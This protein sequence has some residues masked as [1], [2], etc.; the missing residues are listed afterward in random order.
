[1]RILRLT[2]RN[3]NSLRCEATI[4]FDEP[5]LSRAG[6]F[7]ITGPTGAGKTT[8]LDALTLA[9]Y[10]RTPRDSKANEIM[11]NGSADCLAEVEFETPAGRYRAAYA[12]K[13][14][15]G[16]PDGNLQAAQRYL[17]KY[18][19][20]TGEWPY[21]AERLVREVD[22][23]IEA[24]TGL[25]F[26]RFTRSVMLTQGDFARFLAA[27][28]SERGDLLERITGTEIYNQISQAAFE[29]HK[30]A[31]QE[32]EEGRRELSGLELLPPTERTATE[33]QAAEA[34]A[35]AQ[36][37]D[38][39]HKTLLA[40]LEQYRRREQL[41]A[42]L[43]ATDTALTRLAEERDERAEELSI[44]EVV[45]RLRPLRDDL[46][47]WE[48]A[49]AELNRDQERERELSATVLSLTGQLATATTELTTAEA[50]LAAWQ[51]QLPA[52]QEALTR[53]EKL[54]ER[55]RGLQTSREEKD[56]DLQALQAR[57][58]VT[59][60]TITEQTAERDRLT[61]AAAAD[62]K[63]LEEHRKLAEAAA[64]WSNW[65]V[66]IDRR[67]ER[68]GPLQ[69]QLTQVAALEKEATRLTAERK[70]LDTEQHAST[71]RARLLEQQVTALI[72]VELLPVENGRI[73]ARLRVAIEERTTEIGRL[74]RLGGALDAYREFLQRQHAIDEDLGHLER[75]EELL[76]PRLFAA[77]LERDELLHKR[78][79]KRETME[80][81]R[82][83][84]GHETLRRTLV[85]G[86]PCPVC[87]ALDH[88]FADRLGASDFVAE[89]EVELAKAEAALNRAE[90]NL[91]ALS[92]QS[93][94]LSEAKRA[95]E[96]TGAAA[97]DPQRRIEQMEATVAAHLPPGGDRTD[98]LEDA[99]RQHREQLAAYRR[100]E[101]RLAQLRVGQGEEDT[102]SRA[103]ERQFTA[104]RVELENS[105]KNLAAAR[106]AVAAGEQQLAA[107]NTE[108]TD[109]L[110]QTGRAT[111]AGDLTDELVALSKLIRTYG[112]R[113]DAVE[114]AAVAGQLAATKL[115]QAEKTA[116]E[117]SLRAEELLR[118]T[119]EAAEELT[120]GKTERSA[121]LDGR[122]TTV[123]RDL[124][125]R[126]TTAHRAAQETARTLTATLNER[127]ELLVEQQ[128]SLQKRLISAQK[129]QE[130]VSTEL[131]ARLEPLG[132]IEPA[133]ALAALPSPTE[134]ER[135]TIY[136][137]A[138]EK[139]ATELAGSRKQQTAQL[140][141]QDEQL[142]ALPERAALKTEA[143]ATEGR[144][145]NL[146]EQ[147]GILV[148]RLRADSERR[149]R[150]GKLL[151]TIESLTAE[152]HRWSRLNELIGSANGRKY[153]DFAQGLTLA[154]LVGLANNYL[155]KLHGRYLI[156]KQ[157]GTDLEL[158]IIDTYQADNR[159]P[160][161]TLSG[162]ESF[163]VSLALALG[164]SDLAGRH[165]QIKSLF[166]DEG[167][168]SLDPAS[169][170]LALSTLENL[171]AY[172]KTIGIIS[173]V[174]EIKER[175]HHKIEVVKQ[176]DGFSKLR[177]G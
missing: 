61:R 86:K 149:E 120:A 95:I 40:Q 96:K 76:I 100:I 44:Y 63:W 9:L 113:T 1:M 54:D 116:A 30:L 65:E 163:L 157:A 141:A 11:S 81:H 125:E 167:F 48:R 69:T 87:G 132:F 143:A 124:L 39:A 130:K 15:H 117:Q 128:T 75:Q 90:K 98:R 33:E 26:D 70:S 156:A 37:T 84:A 35:A 177:I 62:R 12:R 169:L 80:R 147:V 166:I 88:P 176:R 73:E 22:E 173:H 133:S 94:Q 64:Q 31:R 142:A 58:A 45:Q 123:E 57:Q 74:E 16:K 43:A 158:E 152:E 119:T 144:L 129:T 92:H 102:R 38:T 151:S 105:G 25:D 42:D 174:G 36:E 131:S 41:A 99:L 55:L 3:L 85:A 136:F 77:E 49:A 53:A 72:P 175:I 83:D 23:Q 118:R 7:A 51:A 114:R 78:E 110:R 17:A 71:E 93:I 145:T 115:E 56:L 137:T 32:L 10:G 18:D 8:L 160:V 140:A 5:P 122:I 13:R 126:T 27:K 6:I 148:E 162:G 4:N 2:I 134:E 146:R 159:R 106:E 91:A 79:F 155:S 165:T 101:Q 112:E 172:G 19:P 24:V 127:Q 47:S 21:L 89:A 50:A 46:K 171:Q 97:G 103:T 150:A 121:L 161:Y 28:A 67:R 14:A 107:L 111:K 59:Q 52:R 139:R 60:Q 82:A 68:L 29:R 34:K 20:E 154:K 135:L 153:G 66:K 138:L 104:N 108:L 109:L 170:D 168:G 164:L